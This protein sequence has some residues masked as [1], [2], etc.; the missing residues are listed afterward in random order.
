M[1]IVE[2][3]EHRISEVEVMARAAIADDTGQDGGFEDA[4]DELTGRK[5]SVFDAGPKFADACARMI[6]WNTPRRVLAE[7]AAKRAI[8]DWEKRYRTTV[9]RRGESWEHRATGPL[10][11]LAAIDSDHPDYQKEWSL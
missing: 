5:P 11:I 10:R 9:K 1:T 8:V 4:F 7:C 6:V 3:L 2:F